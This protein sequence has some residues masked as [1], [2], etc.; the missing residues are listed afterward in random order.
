MRTEGIVNLKFLNS[1]PGIE[2]GTSRLLAQC[3]NQLRLLAIALA[4]S[5]N[6]LF[7]SLTR[8]KEVIEYR[9]ITFQIIYSFVIKYSLRIIKDMRNL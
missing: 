1:V 4:E 6:L 2:S 8:N 5:K 7:S 9:R 3:L